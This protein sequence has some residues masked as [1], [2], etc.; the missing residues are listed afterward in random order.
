MGNKII[1]GLLYGW[2]KLHALLPIRVL[3]IYADLLY[4]LIYYV[5]RYRLKVVRR[6]MKASFP[7]KSPA[8][9]RQLEKAFYRHFG[10]YIV[11]SFK[12]AHISLE[13]I[14]R[15]AWINNPEVVD[16]LMAQGHTCL[17]LLM[18][19]YGNWEWFTG[20]GSQFEEACIYQ[21]YRPLNS[22]AMDRLFINLRTQFGSRGIKKNDTIRDIIKLKQE[23][24]RS[25][26]IFLADQTPS[27]GNLHYWTNFLNQ[28]SSI[29]NGP[30]RIARKLDLPVIFL[31]VQ[32]KRRGYYTVDMQLIT[33]EARNTP[34]NWITEQY[35]RR[36][37]QSILRN[38]AFWLWTHK[39][40][41]HKRPTSTP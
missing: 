28:E 29:L 23:R 8:E 1:Y 12:L 13:E 9:L 18:G 22:P 41:K 38:P 26:V 3:Y 14:Q 39:R 6:N 34:E 15:R 37:E 19:H 21:I 10:D 20:S 24:T 7:D 33:A 16:E 17:V 2:V 30:E 31:D 35:A 32:K 4:V 25:V 5:A 36:M 40:W 27:K 11:E